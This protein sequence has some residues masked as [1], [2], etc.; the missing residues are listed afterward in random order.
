MRIDVHHYHHGETDPGIADIKRMLHTMSQAIDDAI[1]KLQASVTNLTAVDTSA[2]ALISGFKA[3][4]DAAVAAAQAAGATPAE[5]QTLT[6]LSASIDNST[7][8]LAAAV[9]ANTPA[10]P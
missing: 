10:A 4:L 6:D 2:V 8:T 5:L 7:Q 9:Q 1:A 3:Q